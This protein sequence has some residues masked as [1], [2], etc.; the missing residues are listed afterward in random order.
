MIFAVHHICADLHART[1]MYEADAKHY[2]WKLAVL[3]QNGFAV[4]TVPM[5][6][7]AH[8]RDVLIFLAQVIDAVRDE[9][10]KQMELT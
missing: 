9:L 10:I 2:L 4:G 5:M 1:N 8:D 6:Q 3:K 7:L